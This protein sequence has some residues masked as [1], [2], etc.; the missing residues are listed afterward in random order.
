FVEGTNVTLRAVPDETSHFESW[1]GPCSGAGVCRFT[2]SAARDVEARFGLCASGAGR[3]FGAAAKRNPRRALVRVQLAG[4]ASARVRLRH[5]GRLIATKTFPGLQL[6]A[7][8]LSV[9]VP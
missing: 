9:Q 7:R 6:G 5:S 4:G 1:S 8:R 2:V 3:S